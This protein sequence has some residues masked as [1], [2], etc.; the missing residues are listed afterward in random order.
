MS[1]HL[2]GKRMSIRSCGL[3]LSEFFNELSKKS[4]NICMWEK[5]KK[6]LWKI[7]DELYT[8][9]CVIKEFFCAHCRELSYLKCILFFYYLFIFCMLEFCKTNFHFFT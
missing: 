6:K 4:T 7:A 8:D 2:S 3:G 1:A 5:V 9:M